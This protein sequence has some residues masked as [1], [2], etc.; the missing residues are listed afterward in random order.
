L[1]SA[2]SNETPMM[3]AGAATGAAH[4]HALLTHMMSVIEPIIKDIE[5][6]VPE[7][8]LAAAMVEVRSMIRRAL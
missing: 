1:V 7:E 5:R 4:A 3:P 8:S 2:A 6:Y